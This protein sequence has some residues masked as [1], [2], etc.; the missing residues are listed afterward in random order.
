MGNAT[1]TGI[2]CSDCGAELQEEQRPCPVCGSAARTY[3]IQMDARAVALSSLKAEARDRTGFK[4]VTQIVREKVAGFSK[5]L[6]REWLRIDRTDRA[7]TRKTHRVEEQRP[8]GQWVTVHDETQEL[9]AKRR[10]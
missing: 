7:V 5:R 1:L 4:K 10:P 9:P 3:S 2:R 6:A 8:D